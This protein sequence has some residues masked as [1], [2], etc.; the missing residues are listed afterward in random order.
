MNVRVR[1]HDRSAPRHAI[2]RA[3]SVSEEYRCQCCCGV[4]ECV[5]HRSVQART[6]GLGIADL[7]A[8]HPAVQFHPRRPC[9]AV[10]LVIPIADATAT[11]IAAA[12]HPQLVPRLSLRPRSLPS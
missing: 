11:S 12:T 3:S 9:F 7:S 1:A 5:A 8:H 4:C 10:V 6:T 2:G